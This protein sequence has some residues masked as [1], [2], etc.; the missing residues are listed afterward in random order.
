M[1]YSAVEEAQGVQ[2]TKELPNI[3][4]IQAK[5]LQRQSSQVS[6]M[7]H[8]SLHIPSD[9]HHSS[10][11]LNNQM[12]SNLHDNRTCELIPSKGNPG[13]VNIE[14][15]LSMIKMTQCMIVIIS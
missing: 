12:E 6:P 4:P 9:D 15:T 13:K 7:G 2:M 11:Y 10:F 5:V 1:V 3:M 8:N 14:S